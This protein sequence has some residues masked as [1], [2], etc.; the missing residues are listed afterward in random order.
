MIFEVSTENLRDIAAA[1]N[2]AR[3]R[4]PAVAVLGA[5]EA[6]VL[7]ALSRR[8]DAIELDGT[9]AEALRNALLQRAYD[10]RDNSEAY[11][12]A[13][14]ADRIERALQDAAVELDET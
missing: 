8:D 4:E 13:D 6:R 7:A 11:D 5:I 12:Y 9:E 2:A 10:Q 14:L 1:I 3:K